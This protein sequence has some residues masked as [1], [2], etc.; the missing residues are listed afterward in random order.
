MQTG[1]TVYYSFLEVK[2]K[3]PDFLLGNLSNDSDDNK[4]TAKQLALHMHFKFWY[5][6]L[7]PS[8]K[9]KLK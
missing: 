2:S 6:S 3:L 9:L 1:L 4:N 7:P 8:A 5:I